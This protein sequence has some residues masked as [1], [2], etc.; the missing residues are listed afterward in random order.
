MSVQ[1]RLVS[2]LSPAFVALAMLGSVPAPSSAQVAK[3]S[4]LTY[5]PLPAFQVPK[6]ARFVLPNGLVVMVLEDH[7]LPLVNGYGRRSALINVPFAV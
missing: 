2:C 4:D 3:P 5:P 6:P 1:R 7:E